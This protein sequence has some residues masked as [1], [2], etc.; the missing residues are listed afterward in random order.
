M[1][2]TRS[3]YSARILV[4][5]HRQLLCEGGILV[6]LLSYFAFDLTHGDHA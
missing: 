6:F 2:S 1:A 5:P 3:L 4:Q